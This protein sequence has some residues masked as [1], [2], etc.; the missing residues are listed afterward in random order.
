MSTATGPA[1]GAAGGVPAELDAGQLTELLLRLLTDDDFRTRLARDGAAATA[2][3][4]AELACLATIDHDELAFTARRFR[5]NLWSGD[6]AAGIA[7][8]FPRSLALLTR[9][10]WNRERLLT[11]FL[12]SPEFAAY[13][14]LPYAGEGIS[15]EEAFGRFAGGPRGEGP[16]PAG[17][18]PGRGG[19]PEPSAG[20][21]CGPYLADTV[22]HETLMALLT[23]LVHEATVSFRVDLPEIMATAHGYAAVHHHPPALIA[24]LRG[25]AP[26]AGATDGERRATVPCLYSSTPRGLAFGP[27][28]PATAEAL[29]VPGHPAA[30]DVRQ[31]LLKRG[32]W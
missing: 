12:R 13:R 16:A 32:L 31:A 6:A 27:V 3:D 7:A 9:A 1:H 29:T 22:K 26:T 8:A 17:F 19:G 28:S 21:D 25:A 20:G 18:E 2:R 4:A 11:A 15:L 23:A 10:G 5:G 24:E 30:D 14:A